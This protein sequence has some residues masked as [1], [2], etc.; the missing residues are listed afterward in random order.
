[1]SNPGIFSLQKEAFLA[2][3]S[4]ARSVLKLQQGLLEMSARFT[5]IVVQLGEATARCQAD[6]TDPVEAFSL[7]WLL[8]KKLNSDNYRKCIIY[9]SPTFV[10]RIFTYKHYSTFVEETKIRHRDM[11]WS[12]R[13]FIAQ[14]HMK[15]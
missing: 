13:T 7:L 15:K 4:I 8:I 9:K 10:H 6:F 3:K 12:D 5:G 11:T 1:M 2:R 14:I